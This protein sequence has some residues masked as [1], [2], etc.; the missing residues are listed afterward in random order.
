[1]G[2][3]HAIHAVSHTLDNLNCV[4]RQLCL[5]TEFGELHVPSLELDV[6]RA[7]NA[8]FTATLASR[9]PITDY[10]SE[11][12]GHLYGFIRHELLHVATSTLPWAVQLRNS[13]D[14]ISNTGA[15]SESDLAVVINTL[16]Q[17]LSD[18]DG[19]DVELVVSP[20][21]NAAASATQLLTCL[22]IL[23]PDAVTRSGDF[24][25]LSTGHFAHSS[26]PS[27]S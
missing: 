11:S 4:K 26:C 7:H 12:L 22:E 19:P 14:T 18:Y 27:L 2:V 9:L 24:G 21:D 6:E 25:L 20:V 10:E 13:Y 16:I 23:T 8:S 15:F 1:L 3:S 5:P 17:D